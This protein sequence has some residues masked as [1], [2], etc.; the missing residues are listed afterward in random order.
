MVK[1]GASVLAADF[2]KLGYEI[3]RAQE[4]GVDLFHVDVMDGHLVSDIAF[5]VNNVKDIC[6]QSRIPV[7][8]HLMTEH[9]QWFAV[10]MA[11]AGAKIVTIQLEPCLE[12]YRTIMDIRSAGAKAHV[13]IN[14]TTPLAML[15]ELYPMVDGILLVTVALGIGGQK[16]IPTMF[17]KLRWLHEIKEAHGYTFQI[18]VDGGV[19]AANR[20][21]IKKC[22]ADY[23][24]AGT[25]IFAAGDLKQTVSML[26][27]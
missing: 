8:A 19:T 6:R 16:I 22:G 3:E 9:P 13:C 18:G 25:T 27:E 2:M 15:D 23:M 10:R 11:E 14:P 1:I 20:A 4:G 21:E 26:K 5:G 7:E 17:E 24:I 12:I